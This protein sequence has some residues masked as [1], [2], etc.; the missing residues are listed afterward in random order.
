MILLDQYEKELSLH[1]LSTFTI[2]PLLNPYIFYLS[3]DISKRLSFLEP[4]PRLPIKE[5]AN[6]ALCGVALNNHNGA[7]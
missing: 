4:Y 7:I 5:V 2:P 3:M 1:S 6:M